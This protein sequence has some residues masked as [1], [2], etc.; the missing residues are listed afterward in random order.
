MPLS[1]PHWNYVTTACLQA[2]ESFSCLGRNQQL[3]IR[4]SI[5]KCL[6]PVVSIKSSCIWTQSWLQK[7][8]SWEIY[9]EKKFTILV[10]AVNSNSWFCF[11]CYIKLLLL[12]NVDTTGGY[13]LLPWCVLW[14]YQTSSCGRENIQFRQWWRQCPQNS[15]SP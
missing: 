14:S 10:T 15:F 11:H 6:V 9:V 7:S 3:Q 4:S 8:I 5:F 1:L 12:Y 2:G 13:L